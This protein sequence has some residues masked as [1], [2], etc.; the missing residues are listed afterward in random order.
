[1]RDLVYEY[2]KGQHD[3]LS[4][5]CAMLAWAIRDPHVS[6]WL[7]TRHK[8]LRTSHG[9]PIVQLGRVTDQAPQSAFV[10]TQPGEAGPTLD[11]NNE[12]KRLFVIFDR[13]DFL[14]RTPGPPPFSCW[15]LV[16]SKVSLI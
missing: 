16:T 5:P 12:Q 4:I 14:R 15:Y 6:A 8:N 9:N 1:M 13:R 2:P 3:N 11:H 7:D 10:R